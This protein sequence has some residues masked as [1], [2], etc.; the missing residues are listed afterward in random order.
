[1]QGRSDANREHPRVALRPATARYAAYLGA[2]T[3]IERNLSDRLRLLSHRGHMSAAM[4]ACALN[5]AL[6]GWVHHAEGR[7]LGLAQELWPEHDGA[8]VKSPRSR[9]PTREPRNRITGITSAPRRSAWRMGLREHGALAQ[10]C[11]E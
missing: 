4:H 9:E 11:V 5:V 7:G 8:A 1:M 3:G 2:A 10:Q 6:L